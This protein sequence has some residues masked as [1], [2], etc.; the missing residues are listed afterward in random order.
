MPEEGNGTAR[1]L[2]AVVE[3]R[4][5][6]STPKEGRGL[7]LEEDPAVV[8]AY[9]PSRDRHEVGEQGIRHSAVVTPALPKDHSA[10]PPTPLISFRWTFPS[11]P[12]VLSNLGGSPRG[13]PTRVS[14]FPLNLSF[15]SLF[16]QKI[17]RCAK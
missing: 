5:G 11:I 8:D 3:A 6:R 15:H 16:L 9:R 10:Y 12:G 4:A 2:R 1:Y 13:L 17:W 7:R 14:R